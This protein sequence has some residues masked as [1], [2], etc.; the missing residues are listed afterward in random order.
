MQDGRDHFIEL[1]IS[2]VVKESGRLMDLETAQKAFG[3]DRIFLIGLMLFLHDKGIINS[4][5]D[6]KLLQ[7]NCRSILKHFRARQDPV[8]NVQLDRTEAELEHFFRSF[9]LPNR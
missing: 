1:G 3:L 5:A 6:M 9:N 7:G 2:R 4:P 8:I